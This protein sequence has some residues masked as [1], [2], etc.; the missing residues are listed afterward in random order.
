MKPNDILTLDIDSIGD[1]G[2]GIA[3]A[4]NSTIYV[5]NALPGERVRAVLT[6]VAKTYAHAEIDKVIRLSVVRAM[7]ICRHYRECGGCQIQRMD[8]R[9][10]LILKRNV[11]IKNLE[12]AGV[13]IDGNI[14]TTIGCQYQQGFRNKAIFPVAKNIDGEIV[15]G[16][17]ERRSHN[18]VPAKECPVGV[19]E[20]LPIVYAVIAHLRRYNID[21]YNEQTHYGIV[22]YIMIRKAFATEEIMVSIVINGQNLPHPDQF[23]HSI[24][25]IERNVKDISLIINCSN[26]N[27][28]RGNEVVNLYGDGYITENLDGLDF[29]LSPLSFFQVN[30]PQT[31]SLYR[32]VLELAQLTGNETVFDLYCG[33]GTIS[34]F[35][36]RNARKVIGVESIPQAVD[37]ANVNAALNHITNAEFIAGKAEEVI[38]ALVSQQGVKADVV[39]VDPPRKGCDKVLIDTII[40][41]RPSRLIYVSCDPKS[42]A[43]DLKILQENGLKTKHVQP[44]D[45]F[46]H[47][48]H[49]ESVAL[50]MP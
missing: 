4:G 25:S 37:D 38:P 36:A 47:T 15:A 43:R 8:Y 2:D 9:E 20:N 26:T 44:V 29:R 19:Q 24:L 48:V 40:Q 41:M 1:D 33:V 11:V 22:R 13:I 50:V 7:P 21:P 28:I 42:L 39:V 49:V 14:P 23:V 12:S 16:F 10:Q 6:D 46:P 18:I 31:L 5:A 32:K 45:M 30:T 27:R 35:L 17:Y 34:L 3:K